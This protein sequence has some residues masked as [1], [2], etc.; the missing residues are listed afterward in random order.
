MSLPGESGGTVSVQEEIKKLREEIIAQLQDM[1][2]MRRQASAMVG[3]LRATCPHSYALVAESRGGMCAICGLIERSHF[4]RRL[5]ILAR[6]SVQL[7][8]YSEFDAYEDLGDIER[9]RRLAEQN[10]E[11]HPR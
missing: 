1:D 7:I 5:N 9:I 3:R 11:K 8:H 4:G 2:R 10:A 6:S